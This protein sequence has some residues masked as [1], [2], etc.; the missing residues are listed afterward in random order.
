ME[1]WHLWVILAFGL[2]VLE[3][4]TFTFA[5]AALALGA[6]V[7]AGAAYFG[8]S[9]VWQLGAL[10]V[11]TFAGFVGARPFVLKR[12]AR[13]DHTY[14]SNFEGLPG[15]EGSVLETVEASAPGIVLIDG[16]EWR[17]VPSDGGRIEVGAPITVVD[18]QG[19][20]LVVVESTSIEG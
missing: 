11:G 13:G 4:L 15:R 20:K 12:L 19:N 10:G 2:L 1:V 5:L 3:A 18:V 14:R 16:D 7:A 6:I 8:L 17:A 9:L